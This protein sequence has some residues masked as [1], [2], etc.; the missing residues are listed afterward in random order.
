MRSTFMAVLAFAFMGEMPAQSVT[1]QISGTVTD[2]GGSVI[3]GSSVRLTHDLSKQARSFSTDGSGN[4]L[5]TNLVPGDYSVHIEHAGFKGYD[6]RG[7]S[8]SA[9]ER[10][11][12]HEIRLTV[13]EVS[14]T[15]EVVGC[16]ALD[17][18]GE[19]PVAIGG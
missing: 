8:V 19:S 14:S 11:A 2:Q 9:E 15:V 13:G 7:I 3:A 12:L 5:C 1:G 6:Q 10:V 18:S 4:F 16:F 17:K